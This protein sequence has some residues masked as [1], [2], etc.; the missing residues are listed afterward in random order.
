MDLLF[1]RLKTLHNQILWKIQDNLFSSGSW[2]ADS[3]TGPSHA[4]P[5]NLTFNASFARDINM[6]SFCPTEMWPSLLNILSLSTS[7]SLW[8]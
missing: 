8:T 3:V 2:R 5:Y 7:A 4:F 1:I 6:E